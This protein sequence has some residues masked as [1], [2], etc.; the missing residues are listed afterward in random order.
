MNSGRI[1]EAI[2]V[3]EA[4]V[5][6]PSISIEPRAVPDLLAHAAV[7]SRNLGDFPRAKNLHKR[8]LDFAASD[9]AILYGLAEVCLQLNESDAAGTF[10]KRCYELSKAE[11]NQ[12]YLE[13]VER[14]ASFWK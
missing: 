14:R 11:N 2:S 9:P 3:I 5:D 4:S 10:F 1:S 8:A 13:L 12:E 6:D 7:L